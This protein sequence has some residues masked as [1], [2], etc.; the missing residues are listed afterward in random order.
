MMKINSLLDKNIVLTGSL[1]A[2]KREEA[3]DEIK[4]SGGLVQNFVTDKTD[5]LVLA[6]KQLNIF[7]SDVRSRKL[8]K[9]EILKA[10]GSNI[11]I[12]SE[13]EFLSL[14]KK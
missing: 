11:E 3:I 2:M 7:G 10:G 4:K 8:I 1:N 14:L 12:I 5:I 9:A 13:K 6:P